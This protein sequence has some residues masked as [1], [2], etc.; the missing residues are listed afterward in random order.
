MRTDDQGL[1]FCGQGKQGNTRSRCHVG[2][3]VERA[4]PVGMR[5]VDRQVADVA[6]EDRKPVFRLDEDGEVPRSVARSRAE[7]ELGGELQRVV[8]ERE[9]TCAI[10]RDEVLVE[11]RDSPGAAEPLPVAAP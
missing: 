11:L 2:M 8:D 1:A 6:E 7:D 9:D 4:D 3:R 10:E 5:D